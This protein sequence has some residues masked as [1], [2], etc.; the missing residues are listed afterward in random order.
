MAAALGMILGA[1]TR[2]LS[3][4]AQQQRQLEFQQK[5]A[6]N[7]ML[8]D[9]F[10][11]NPADAANPAFAKEGKKAFG[12][13]WDARQQIY[14]MAATHKQ[15]EDTQYEK[16]MGGGEQPIKHPQ[17]LEEWQDFH[18]KLIAGR[19]HFSD[20]PAMLKGVDDHIASAEKAMEELR[21]QQ[22]QT[23]RQ[24]AGFQNDERLRQ[25]RHADSETL[26]RDRIGA[27]TGKEEKMIGLREGAN[28]DEAR[29]KKE[30]GLTGA[31]DK[32]AK[33]VDPMVAANRAG[34]VLTKLQKQA[35]TQFK[36]K[37]PTFWH[38]A[39]HQKWQAD[40]EAWVAKQATTAG[41]NPET[42]LPLSMSPVEAPT[43]GTDNVRTDTTGKKW[44]LNAKG[45]GW[46]PAK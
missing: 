16:L 31:G 19:Q 10:N 27:E 20:N 12:E 13:T 18:D 17:T 44:K 30:L 46:E 14:G 15:A 33:P 40:K 3:E 29:K 9:H 36:D 11:K 25:E 24:Q 28:I 43:G 5:E 22:G 35:D 23:E 38:R 26:L 39:E 45:D 7:Q 21:T 2:M 32:P 4:H 6:Y 42:G 37:E 8:E 34:V 1:G 41:V